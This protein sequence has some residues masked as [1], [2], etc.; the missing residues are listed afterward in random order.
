[1]TAQTLD[2][3][4]DPKAGPTQTKKYLD[5]HFN[6]KDIA[7]EYGARWDAGVKRWYYPRG[8]RLEIIFSW[9]IGAHGI[10]SRE[11]IDVPEKDVAL[12][13]ELGAGKTVST[14]VNTKNHT[15]HV[16]P[17]TKL[18]VIYSW[19][20]T[21]GR[22]PKTSPQYKLRAVKTAKDEA[23]DIFLPAHPEW[24]PAAADIIEGHSLTIKMDDRPKARALGIRA[25]SRR[26][27]IPKV[28]TGSWYE[29]I[30]SWCP[31]KKQDPL[32]PHAL[33]IPERDKSLAEYLGASETPDGRW[34]SRPGSI[35]HT[36]LNW[37]THYV[38]QN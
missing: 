26:A 15:Y 4:H 23:A 19:R 27:N 18:S 31:Y 5:V 36:A 3:P 32:L 24:D 6:H 9:R 13:N 7:K 16:T 17:F 1:M 11:L 25:P 34:L 37:R 20:K 8:S 38:P 29:R 2:T 28:L 33:N 30:L 12:A 10:G 21:L 14:T 22:K 35:L